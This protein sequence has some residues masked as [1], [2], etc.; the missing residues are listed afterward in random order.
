MSLKILYVIKEN[1]IGC[2]IV[3]NVKF[4]LTVEKQPLVELIHFFLAY[5][6][7]LLITLASTLT[8]CYPALPK[9]I[10]IIVITKYNASIMA[11]FIAN[12]A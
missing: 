10:I 6:S 8:K 2:L 9:K 4:T 5:M 11:Y 12:M 1:Y 3:W 7:Q